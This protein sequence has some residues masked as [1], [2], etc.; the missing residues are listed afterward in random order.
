MIIDQCFS[1]KNLMLSFLNEKNE[2]GTCDSEDNKERRPL[3]ER[4]CSL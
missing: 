2:L 1:D 3:H 4:L